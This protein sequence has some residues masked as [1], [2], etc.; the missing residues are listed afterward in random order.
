MEYSQLVE[1]YTKL[2]ATASKLEKTALLADFFSNTPERLLRI[3]PLLTMGKIFPEG[4]SLDLGIGPGLLYDAVC[5]VAGI[6]KKTLKDAVRE[7][8][9]VGKAVERLLSRK[10][11]VTL[12]SKKLTVS[13]VYTNFYK[14]AKCTGGGAQGKKTKLLAD[15]LMDATPLDTRYIVRTVLGELRAGVAEGLVRDAIARAFG[16]SPQVVE[17]AYMLTNDFGVVAVTARKS[18]EEGLKRLSVRVGV[19]LKPMLAQLAP[20][21]EDA[22]ED[23]GKAAFEVKYDGARIQLHKGKDGM[24][25][26]SRR[27]EDVTQ[28]L[29]DVV[30]AAYK[31]VKAK[32]VIMEGEAVAVDP[33]TRRPKAFQDILRRFRRKYDVDKMTREI[34]F[35]T[36]IFDILYVDGETMID[37]PFRDRRKRLEEVIK[38]IARKLELAQ[39]I[40]TDDPRVAEKFY[41]QALA[42]GHEG[43][44]IK[45]LDAPYIPGARVGHMYKI[46]P[47]METLDLVIT[48]GLWGTGKRTGWLSSYILAVRDSEAGGFLSVGRVGTGVT[49]EQLEEFTQRL[50][51]LI[52]SEA[53]TKVRVKP[54]VVVEVA[55][56]E[57]QRSPK[58]KSGYALRFPRIVRIREDKSPD[59]ADTMERIHRLYRLQRR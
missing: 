23:I 59:D 36:Y 37:V 16:V 30:E 9:D 15:L 24:K 3:V 29:P 53:G 45:N 22:L 26:F 4:S 58:Y 43:V 52:E 50:K 44:M 14:I 1:L 54:E 40:I 5:F 42:M 11:Q 57:I 55:F 21:I 35:E 18:G 47:V 8:G 38:P 51:P 49:E 27:L 39:Q 7:E 17:R 25:I 34:P 56:Q 48:G 41:N 10:S 20:S 19:P 28:A 31:T 13:R 46:K 2:E 12:F 33:E 6:N 32:E